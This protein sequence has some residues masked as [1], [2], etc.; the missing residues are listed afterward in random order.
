MN[1]SFSEE[2]F[3]LTPKQRRSAHILLCE[4]ALE[5]WIT[6]VATQDSIEY[7][8]SITG[9]RQE[10]D[11]QLPVDSLTSVKENLDARKV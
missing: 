11:K 8:E 10:V 6:Y 4:H 3:A 5:K 1:K 9:T 7:M 2:F